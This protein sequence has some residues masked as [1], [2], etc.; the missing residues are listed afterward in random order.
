MYVRDIVARYGVLVSIVSN[1]DIRFTSQFWQRVCVELGTRLHFKTDYHPQTDGQSERKI[2]TLEDIMSPCV[3][4]FSGS[5]DSFLPFLS[6]LTTTAITPV[7]VHH[8]TKFSME[9]SVIHQFDGER[10][11]TGL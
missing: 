4:N 3:V 10:W 6:F 9:G 7:L 5:W 2:K 8:R 1:H 11:D